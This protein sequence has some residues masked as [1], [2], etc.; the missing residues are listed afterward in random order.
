MTEQNTT[1]CGDAMCADKGCRRPLAKRDEWC[2][3][4]ARATTAKRRRGIV[5]GNRSLH[6]FIM[7]EAA[8]CSRMKPKDPSLAPPKEKRR[9]KQS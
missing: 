8:A 1:T 9:G 4:A 5:P 7:R 2:P 6:D 3:P